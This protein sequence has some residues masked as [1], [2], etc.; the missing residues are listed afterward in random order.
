MTRRLIDYPVEDRIRAFNVAQQDPYPPRRPRKSHAG[1]F[2][3][4]VFACAVLA[5]LLA[6]FG[7]SV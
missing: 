2:V 5:L 7:D 1:D 3:A 4:L 6:V